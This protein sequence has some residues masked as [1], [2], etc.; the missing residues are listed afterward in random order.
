MQQSQR[1]SSQSNPEAKYF[2]EYKPTEKAREHIEE[3]VRKGNVRLLNTFAQ[4]LGQIFINKMGK[5]KELTTS[6]VRSIL[7][8]IQSIDTSSE[9]SVRREL[10]LLRPKLAYAAGRHKGRV[11]QFQG[12][13]DYAIE[14][15]TD[16]NTKAPAS[17]FENLKAFIEAVVAYHRYYG[18]RE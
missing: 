9:D 6:Q 16:P 13:I 8:D 10:E 12:V 11:K 2:R 5:E 1:T 18:G 15:V 3:I 7:D 17:M 14:L 4:E